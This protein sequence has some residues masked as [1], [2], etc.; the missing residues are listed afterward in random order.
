MI[1]LRKNR[2][3]Q[4]KLNLI[5]GFLKKMLEEERRMIIDL[6]KKLLGCENLINS[7][8][9]IHESCPLFICL[10]CGNRCDFIK[11]APPNPW[12]AND[13]EAVHV[14]LYKTWTVYRKLSSL[15]EIERGEKHD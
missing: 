10:R 11:R 3:N 9:N 12:R 2:K 14:L 8:L 13:Y 1:C 4:K 5:N 15:L 6:A 7:L